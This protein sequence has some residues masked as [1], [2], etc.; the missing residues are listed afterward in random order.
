[1]Y[2]VVLGNVT[3]RKVYVVLRVIVIN[4][5]ENNIENNYYYYYNN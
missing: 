4:I 1:M 2:W 5:S 3:I